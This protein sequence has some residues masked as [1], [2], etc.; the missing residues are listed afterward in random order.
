MGSDGAGTTYDLVAGPL[1]S[2]A[3]ATR[4]CQELSAQATPC[5]IGVYSGDVL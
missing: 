5:S 1:K 3:E 2:A 4:L